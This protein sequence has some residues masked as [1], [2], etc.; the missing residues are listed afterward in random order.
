MKTTTIT[1]TEAELDAIQDGLELKAEMHHDCA[2]DAESEAEWKEEK[3]LQAEA[4]LLQEKIAGARRA[5]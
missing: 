2:Q 4:E 5:A 1:L 3:R